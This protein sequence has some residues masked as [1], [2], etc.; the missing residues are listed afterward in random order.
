MR[1]RWELII[2]FIKDLTKQR[3][4]NFGYG[5]FLHI[6]LHRQDV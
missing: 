1:N 2:I 6:D 3:R 4:R 5:M